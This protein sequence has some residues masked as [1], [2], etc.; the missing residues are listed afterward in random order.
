MPPIQTNVEPSEELWFAF[1]QK[2]NAELYDFQQKSKQA[3]ETVLQNINKA[4]AELLAKHKK[5]EEEFWTK[6]RAAS[7]DKS[8]STNKS[9]ASKTGT[10]GRN[11][12]QQAAS[13]TRKA[14]PEPKRTQAV[15]SKAP[16]T[17]TPT[18]AYNT[19]TQA[20]QSKKRSAAVTI[21]DLCS[22]EDEPVKE[23]TKLAPPPIAKDPVLES[24]KSD[25]IEGAVKREHAIPSASLELFGKSAKQVT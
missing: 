13:P 8:K 25:I 11:N 14:T 15:T 2:H 19:K 22:D 7:K 10:Q 24:Q 4:K 23:Q 17:S 21:I 12:R 6:A 3:Y 1:R 9:A 18:P 16:Q 20:R 5:E